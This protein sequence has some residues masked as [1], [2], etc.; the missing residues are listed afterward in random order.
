[1]VAPPSMGG[2]PAH[3]PVPPKPAPMNR[4]NG[5]P[6]I[7]APPAIP[8]SARRAPPLDMNTVERRGHPSS[9]DPPSRNRPYEL[10]EAPTFRPTD[11]EFRDPMEYIKSISEK[12]SKFGICKIIPPDNWDPEFAIDLTVCSIVSFWI[13][14]VS[15]FSVAITAVLAVLG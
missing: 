2:Q 4:P 9:R 15:T 8:Y 5:V 14:R 11:E 10:M 3:N 12:A 13:F 1:M 7:T 6:P